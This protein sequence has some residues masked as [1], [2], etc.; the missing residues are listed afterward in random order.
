EKLK[1]AFPDKADRLHGGDIKYS[2]LVNKNNKNSRIDNQVLVLEIYTKDLERVKYDEDGRSKSKLKY[3]NGRVITV[4]PE[5]GI[6]LSDKANPYKSDTSPFPFVLLKD[7][8]VPGKFWG[9]GE[10]Q[11]LLSPQKYMNEL[12]NAI[13]DNAKVTAN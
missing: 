2:E 3:P 10:V 12:N 4:C 8:D 6:V 5:L 1:R 9:E 13:I 11:Q 7:Y